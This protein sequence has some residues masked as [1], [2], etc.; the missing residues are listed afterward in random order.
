MLTT[1]AAAA[2]FLASPQAISASASTPSMFYPTGTQVAAGLDHTCVLTAGGA[3]ACWGNNGNGQVGNSN[4]GNNLT[5]GPVVGLNRGIAHI[6]AGGHHTCALTS[7]SAVLCWGRNANGEVGDGTTVDKLVPMTVN[8]TGGPGLNDIVDI[9]AGQYH[10]CAL[11]TAGTVK[12]WGLNADGELGDG[13]HTS[14]TKAVSVLGLTQQVVAVAAGGFH[15]CALTATGLVYCWGYNG[16]YQLGDGTNVAR[17][18]PVAVSGLT[19][20]AAIAAGGAHTCALTRAA[21]VKCWGNNGSGQLGHSDM[22]NT[23]TP[24]VVSNLGDALAIAAGSG[25][26][27]ALVAAGGLRCWGAN[28]SGQLGN[29]GITDTST[30]VP[31]SG[32]PA[33]MAVA[34]GGSHTCALDT[35][36]A[37][38]CWGYNAYGQLG[39]DS[40]SS[41]VTPSAPSGLSSGAIAI[42]AGETHTCALTTP[43]TV[44]CWGDNDFGQLGDGSPTGRF[45]PTA[46][47]SLTSG[48]LSIKGGGRHTCALTSGGAAKCWGDNSYGQLGDGTKVVRTIPVPV[49]GLS[50]DVGAISAGGFHTCAVT[51]SGAVKCWGYNNYGQLGIGV[52]S[53]ESAPTAVTGLAT[54]AAAVATGSFHT[55]AVTSAG[56]VKCWGLNS[57]GQLGNGSTDNS[58]TP[59][60]VPSL[61]SGVAAV[62]AGV[63]HTCALTTAGAVKCWGDNQYGELGDGSTSNRN[64]P[65]AVSSLSSGVIA[66]TTGNRFTCALTSTGAVKCWGVNGSGQL[67][68]GTYTGRLTPVAVNDLQSGVTAISAGSAHVCA[69]S[70]ASTVTCWG[71]NVYGQI[72]A[73]APVDQ[74]VPKS[75][76]AGQAI[77]FV[78]SARMGA[79][80]LR[81]AF[82]SA[83]GGAVSFDTLTPAICGVDASDNTLFFSPAGG[84]CGLRASQ[85]GS[86]DASV[87]AAPQQL[88]LIRVEADLLFA[89]GLDVWNGMNQ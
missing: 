34:T 70:T 24:T 78:P 39:D 6:T 37:L 58:F 79:S 66:V 57:S 20:V 80:S 21:E 54:G 19:N 61:T 3:V 12:C 49:S 5:S 73:T 67:G 22:N 18:Q 38:K 23:P 82:A 76:L 53:N 7:T 59:V 89:S 86:S 30:P 42:S 26:T 51:A 25:H 56:A 68:D 2:I 10:T 43:G 46:V 13:S 8:D 84:L 52:G 35:V 77:T 47:A 16:S 33:V 15:T 65:T 60:A 11:T 17:I 44:T 85:A 88:R 74:S 50:S 72:L 75:L 36:G 9:S 64:E 55:C 83:A 45:M 40:L 4:T 31:V 69:L 1:V 63:A 14:K 32:M 41:K 81:S 28:S 48:V 71:S 87:A 62:S 29:G 27:C